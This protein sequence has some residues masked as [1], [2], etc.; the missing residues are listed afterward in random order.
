M[1]CTLTTPN[2]NR[3]KSRIKEHNEA[4][5]D[6]LSEL[7]DQQ[8]EA[9]SLVYSAVS[10]WN[11]WRSF[12][13]RVNAL[14]MEFDFRGYRGEVL[15]LATDSTGLLKSVLKLARD[16]DISDKEL[17]ELILASHESGNLVR[18]VETWPGDE[19]SGQRR[20]AAREA[21]AAGNTQSL[22]AALQNA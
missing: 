5:R 15:R 3:T 9:K 4:L 2:V 16:R 13:A 22:E 7:C 20:A 8:A 10:L 1:S 6:E 19:G 11:D 12:I 21:V 17:S 14:A 18:W